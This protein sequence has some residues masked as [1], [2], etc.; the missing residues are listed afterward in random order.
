M[1]AATRA[2]EN[3]GYV[4]TVNIEVVGMFF[5]ILLDSKVDKGKKRNDSTK[6]MR[7]LENKYNTYHRMRSQPKQQLS[8][9]NVMQNRNDGKQRYTTERDST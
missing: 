4:L 3:P 5:L 7:L 6:I 9:E 2:E 8:N 1:P